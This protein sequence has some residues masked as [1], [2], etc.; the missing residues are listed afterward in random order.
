[1]DNES[2]MRKKVIAVDF[3]GTCFDTDDHGELVPVPGA[4]DALSLLKNQGY[5]LVIHTCRTTI[6][7][8]RGSLDEEVHFIESILRSHGFEYDEIHLGEKLVADAY[9]DDRAIAFRGNWEK[10]L[11]QLEK[12][13]NDFD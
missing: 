6:A 12:Y 3:D 7:M 4:R 10:T 2:R 5:H 1:M 13:F 11:D 8:D 9:V